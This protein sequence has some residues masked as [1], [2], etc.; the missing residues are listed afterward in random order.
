MSRFLSAAHAALLLS[1]SF[2]VA[3]CGG[4]D[5]TPPNLDP[6]GVWYGQKQSRLT[7]R[8]ENVRALV[9]ADGTMYALADQEE[10]W[11]GS[12]NVDDNGNTSL[13]AGE[14]LLVTTSFPATLSNRAA[15][16]WQGGSMSADRTMRASY[17]SGGDVGQVVLQARDDLFGGAAG[18]S[19]L[20]GSYHYAPLGGQGFFPSDFR[21]GTD[22]VLTGTETRGTFTGTI[23]QIQPAR[24]AYAVTL[25]YV[26]FRFPDVQSRSEYVT[27]L[28]AGTSPQLLLFATADRSVLPLTKVGP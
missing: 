18:L 13:E 19:A 21:I 12:I 23:R 5:D 17:A 15:L 9:L 14:A 27:Y 3:G 10:I 11:G 6:Q 26:D 7:G 16:V 4:S 22:G 8:V 20:A 28:D 1:L 24:N 2:V 25:T